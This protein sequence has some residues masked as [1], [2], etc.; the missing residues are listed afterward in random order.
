MI[1][2]SKLL[3]FDSFRQ[4]RRLPKFQPKQP[5][6]AASVM[7]FMDVQKSD[8]DSNS[9]VM[10]GGWI[11]SNSTALSF[12]A[13]SVTGGN[14]WITQKQQSPPSFWD[15][16]RELRR[17]KTPKE[18]KPIISVQDFFRSIKNSVEELKVVD[19]R[20]AGYEATI[21]KAL[22]AGQTALVEHLKFGLDTARTEAQMAA[23]GF[24]E[25]L[26]EEVVVRFAKISPRGLDLI[27]LENFVRVIPDHVLDRKK[28]ADEHGLFD[29]YVVLAYDPESTAKK[30]TKA[31]IER[32]KDPILFGLIENR[33][34]LY[35]I[36]D[37]VDELCDLTLDQIADKL[38]RDVIKKV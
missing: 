29:N 20:S 15:K 23:A 38:G 27:W 9:P 14:V 3:I 1:R 6:P 34:R 10:Q 36:G 22:E 25:Y 12:A 5:Q 24:D 26:E 17:P 2:D 37:W 35:Y 11:T 33:R 7:Q 19:E 28:K 4:D 30:D 21:K 13:N 31:E 18:P 16:V 8:F 32:K